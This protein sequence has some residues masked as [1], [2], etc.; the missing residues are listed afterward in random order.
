MDKSAKGWS[1]QSKPELHSSQTEY[2]KGFGGKF[3]VDREN[4]DQSAEGYGDQPAVVGT[5][6][7]KT[8]ANVPCA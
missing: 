1:E 6:Y 3:G 4:Q 5:S 2:K 7:K 8:V